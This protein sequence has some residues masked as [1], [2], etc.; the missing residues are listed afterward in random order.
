MRTNVGSSRV[1]GIQYDAE[2]S[3]K[4]VEGAQMLKDPRG[5]SRLCVCTCP[6][7]QFSHASLLDDV[8][9]CL[10]EAAAKLEVGRQ[11]LMW[12][13]SLRGKEEDVA[14]IL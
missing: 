1:S 13:A 2:L 3:F 11:T 6:G 8:S 12:L 7:E 10:L 5:N 4:A 9:S 14:P